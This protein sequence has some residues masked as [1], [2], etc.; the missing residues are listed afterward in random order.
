MN[1]VKVARKK[2]R[3]FN[4]RKS[5]M[6]SSRVSSQMNAPISPTPAT[7]VQPMMK[8]EPNQSSRSPLSRTTWR[9]PSPTLSSPSPM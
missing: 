3:S 7:R 8:F 5:T 2:F 6:G 1:M 4:M 9:K